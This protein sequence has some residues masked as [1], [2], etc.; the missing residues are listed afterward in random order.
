[1]KKDFSILSLFCRCSGT[2]DA[3]AGTDKY[4]CDGESVVIGGSSVS[5]V[6]FYGAPLKD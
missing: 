5:A 3:D 2:L 4:I 1:V 6:S